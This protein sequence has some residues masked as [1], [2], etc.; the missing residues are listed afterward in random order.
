MQGGAN[1]TVDA[2]RV[3][4]DGSLAP[5]GTVTVPGAQGG[6]GIVAT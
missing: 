3:N 5:L 2:F 1:G 6:Q 4:G